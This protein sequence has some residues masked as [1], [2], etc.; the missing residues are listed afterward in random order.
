LLLSFQVNLRFLLLLDPDCSW[1]TIAET[2]FT[3]SESF[4]LKYGIYCIL[5]KMEDENLHKRSLKFEFSLLF[6]PYIVSTF[7][8]RIR[9]SF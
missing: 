7:H 1:Q 8:I 9:P 5:K 2:S 6:A 4:L 3:K